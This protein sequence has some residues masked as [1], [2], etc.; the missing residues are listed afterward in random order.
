MRSARR[1]TCSTPLRRCPG[2]KPPRWALEETFRNPKDIHFGLGPS[3]THVGSC[4]RRGR[5]LLLAA[6]AHAL[7]TLLGAAEARESD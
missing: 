1:A 3:A 7:L 5:L 4:D 6:I 2:H